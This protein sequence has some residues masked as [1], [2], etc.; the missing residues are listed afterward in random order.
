MQAPTDGLAVIIPARLGS[1]RFPGKLLASIAGRTVLEWTWHQVCRAHLDARIWIATDSD[2]IAQAALGFGA[3]VLRTGRHDSGSDRVGA[4][5]AQIS[6]PPGWVI[7]V[8]GDEPLLDPRA[9]SRVALTLREDPQAIVTCAAPLTSFEDWLDPSVVKVVCSGD[10][11][12]LYFSR[13]PIPGSHA[14]PSREAFAWV[15]R[16]VWRHVGIYGYPLRTLRRYLALPH[17]P[18]EEIE[19]LEQL[20]ALEAGIPIRVI[21]LE[22]AAPAVDTPQ[23]LLQVQGLLEEEARAPHVQPEEGARP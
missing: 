22:R 7:N 3:A 21:M 15:R 2:E 11:R 23:D 8:Q 5:A 10:G 9:V 16:L 18:L 12:A 6:P 13:Q 20:R 19:C 1:T 4:A 17:S 14:A